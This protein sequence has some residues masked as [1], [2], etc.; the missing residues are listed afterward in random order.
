MH[1]S[2]TGNV[3]EWCLPEDINLEGVEFKAMASG[4]H[5]LVKDFVYDFSQHLKHT[6]FK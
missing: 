3:V 1:H 2:V 6:S 5:T 4:S